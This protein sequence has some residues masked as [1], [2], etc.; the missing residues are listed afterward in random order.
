METNN[1]HIELGTHDVRREAHDNPAFQRQERELERIRQMREQ[2]R[3]MLGD[4][5][6]PRN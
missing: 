2:M 1:K 5:H 4:G 3:A 6:A